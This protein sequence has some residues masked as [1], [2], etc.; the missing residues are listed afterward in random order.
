MVLVTQEYVHV[1]RKSGS[2][3]LY[4]I[5]TAPFQTANPSPA[6]HTMSTHPLGDREVAEYPAQG[7]SNGEL[8]MS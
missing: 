4:A 3:A 1:H 8:A 2:R 7:Y 6:C 5:N